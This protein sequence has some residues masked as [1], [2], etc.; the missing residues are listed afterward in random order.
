MLQTLA[1]CIE[2]FIDTARKT[3]AQLA[4]IVVLVDV[5]HASGHGLLEVLLHL[6]QAVAFGDWMLLHEMPQPGNS[7]LV[8]P[9][10]CESPKVFGG[11]NLTMIGWEHDNGRVG[12]SKWRVGIPQNV[13]QASR[14]RCDI[15]IG[16]EPDNGRV[17]TSKWGGGIPQNVEQASRIRCDIVIGWESENDRV[18]T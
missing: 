1:F 12:T 2:Q 15:M 5:L 8:R 16:W 10:T 4:H 3:C 7:G 17:G 11:G 18:G 14:I 6:C 13:Q 9:E